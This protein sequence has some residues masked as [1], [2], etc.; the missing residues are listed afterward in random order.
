MGRPATASKLL[1]TDRDTQTILLVYSYWGLTADVIKRALYSH[2]GPVG[3]TCYRRLKFLALEQFL[4]ARRI[5]TFSPFG[6]SRLFFT[7]GKRGLPIVARALTLPV[8]D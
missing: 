5:S 6:T 3:T 4:A 7:V 2:G 1:L 8:G